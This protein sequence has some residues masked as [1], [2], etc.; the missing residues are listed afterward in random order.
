MTIP[1]DILK[2]DFTRAVKMEDGRHLEGDGYLWTYGVGG[3]WATMI[4]AQGS[5]KNHGILTHYSPPH[6]H[7]NRYK[8]RQLGREHPEMKSAQRKGAVILLDDMYDL[9]DE[10]GYHA[11]KVGVHELAIK[12][13]FGEMEVKVIQYPLF[14]PDD[15]MRE[16]IVDLET[17]RWHS[18]FACGTL[19]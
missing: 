17:G 12:D 19:I 16:V 10:L 1:D 4:Y 5:G 18:W 11:T 2:M 3:C 8:L 9:A 7:V 14:Y 6:F 15:G 13:M